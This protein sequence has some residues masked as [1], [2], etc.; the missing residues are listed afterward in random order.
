MVQRHT[1]SGNLLR[2]HGG[3][4]P[5]HGGYILIHGGYIPLHGSYIPVHASDAYAS[6]KIY[7]SIMADTDTDIVDQ[8]NHISTCPT[9]HFLQRDILVPTVS[10]GVQRWEE[11][12]GSVEGS[13]I[14][15][16]LPPTAPHNIVLPPK[17]D[18]ICKLNPPAFVSPPFPPF[19]FC[20]SDLP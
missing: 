17:P 13:S 16:V 4:I 9:S 2:V 11:A 8:I 15:I 6:K 18:T 20:K 14:Q 10:F 1:H 5:V 3:Y 12:C 7:P 19:L